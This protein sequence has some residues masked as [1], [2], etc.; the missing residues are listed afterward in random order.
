MKLNFQVILVDTKMEHILTAKQKKINSVHGSILSKNIIEIAE[1]YG[2]GKLLAI[3]KS[4]ETNLLA[5]MEYAELFG[6]KN[7]MRICTYR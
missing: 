5:T 1:T 2:Y 6:S 7:V 4:D 3:T